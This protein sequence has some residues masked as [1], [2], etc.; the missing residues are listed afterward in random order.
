MYTRLL[1]IPATY[2]KSGKVRMYPVEYAYPAATPPDLQD[3]WD[4]RVPSRTEV[5]LIGRT[6]PSPKWKRR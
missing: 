3:Y 2:R 5:H 1:Q 4:F 6:K